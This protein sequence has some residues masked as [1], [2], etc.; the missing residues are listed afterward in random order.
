MYA[1]SDWPLVPAFETPVFYVFKGTTLVG[2]RSGWTGP[3]DMPA[4]R[5]LVLRAKG[6]DATRKSSAVNT[7]PPIDISTLN[8]KRAEFDKQVV[9]VRGYLTMGPESLY[10]VSKKGNDA[11]FWKSDSGCL[12]LLNTGNPDA[13]EPTSNG[14]LVEI[15]GTFQADNSSYGLSLSQCGTS[16]IDLNGDI[17]ASM[18]RPSSAH[19]ENV[20]D[21]H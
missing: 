17:G 1:R 2:S 6:D 12:S 9:T 13:V 18:R 10:V 5:E 11:D 4:L 21:A 19:A 14:K 20:Q 16:G 15:T 8:L 3:K 7:E